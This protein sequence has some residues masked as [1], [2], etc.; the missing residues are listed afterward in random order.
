M[1]LKRGVNAGNTRF[2]GNWCVQKQQLNSK[3]ATP[4]HHRQCH[5]HNSDRNKLPKSTSPPSSK[6]NMEARGAAAAGGAAGCAAAATSSS[7]HPCRHMLSTATHALDVQWKPEQEMID[8][9]YYC[10]SVSIS[11][12]S[13]V[14]HA[15][16]RARQAGSAADRSPH[17]HHWHTRHSC[18]QRNE[19]RDGGGEAVFRGG[20]CAEGDARTTD[21][22]YS[23]DPEV[24][25]CALEE[26]PRGSA[27]QAVRTQRRRGLESSGWRGSC[28]L[29]CSRWQREAWRGATLL[30][31]GCK[32]FED[33]SSLLKGVGIAARHPKACQQQQLA[34]TG[35]SSSS[36]ACKRVG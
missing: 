15:P 29:R 31:C 1:R 21:T 6:S 30:L 16:A 23:D 24:G 9:E 17:W 12:K 20:A 7:S 13:T 4:H 33:G 36:V 27:R 22:E 18:R 35:S 34:A 14:L 32:I 11:Q 5:H 25:R 10:T 26:G 2:V 19:G 28:W 8:V 3:T